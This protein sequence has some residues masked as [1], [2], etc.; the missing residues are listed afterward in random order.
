MSNGSGNKLILAIAVEATFG[1]AIG[2]QFPLAV[3]ENNGFK[4]EATAVFNESG[5]GSTYRY[6]NYKTEDRWSSFS[7]EVNIDENTFLIP[8]LQ[9]Y[10]IASNLVPSDSG[11]YEHVLTY[12]NSNFLKSFR[13]TLV[14][15]DRGSTAAPT[16][17]TEEYKGCL[18]SNIQFNQVKG[19]F[20]TMTLEGIGIRSEHTVATVPAIDRIRE[21]VG[22]QVVNQLVGTSSSFADYQVITADHNLEFKLADIESVSPLGSSTL[23]SQAVLDDMYSV[24]LNALMPNK[25]IQDNYNN[26]TQ[27]KYKTIITDTVRDIIGSTNN[28][29]PSIIFEM[30]RVVINEYKEREGSMSELLRQTFTCTAI[31]IPS[32]TG[33]PASLIVRNNVA[34]Y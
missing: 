21:F 29:K 2:T 22:S 15:P 5:M 14:D 8:F 28:T 17:K 11:A 31:D 24:T 32:V 19:Q 18:I 26:A 7:V 9:K 27:L 33:S 12:S 25:D 30:P 1:G 13:F 3:V 16:L 10:T 6:S 20:Q 23:T 34:S 4:N